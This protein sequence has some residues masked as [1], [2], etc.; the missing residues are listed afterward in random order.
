MSSSKLFL[1]SKITVAG[2]TMEVKA[3]AVVNVNDAATFNFHASTLTYKDSTIATVADIETAKAQLFGLTAPEALDTIQELAA[4]FQTLNGD[5]EGTIT[6]QLTDHNTRLNTL[7]TEASQVEGEIN[8]AVLVE[9][10]RALAAEGVL[11]TNIN[12]EESRAL[13]AEGVLQTSID[14]VAADLLAAEGSIATSISDSVAVEKTRAEGIESGLQ[15]SID[16]V[17]ADLLA[18]EGSIAAS[19]SDSV[20]VEKTRAEGAESALETRIR[21]L[22]TFLFADDAMPNPY[23]DET[24]TPTR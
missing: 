20:A 22:Y 17:A 12:T 15:S 11:Q 16:G 19:I 23:D 13:A 10:T 21:Q 9:K 7:E 8:A 14:G 5:L 2:S 1:G 6:S 4:A 3:D 18:A 24:F